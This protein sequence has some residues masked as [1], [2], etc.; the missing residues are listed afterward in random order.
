MISENVFLVD[1]D[2]HNNLASIGARFI[3]FFIDCAIVYTTSAVA[4]S[5]FLQQFVDYS[6]PF[7]IDTILQ[8]L[9]GYL[10]SLLFY[11]LWFVAYFSI[12][13]AVCSQTVGKIILQIKVVDEKN[14]PLTFGSALIRTL[15][16]Y[17]SAIPFFIGFFLS[18]TGTKRQALHDRISGS[19]V[20][21][22]S[23][24]S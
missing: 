22:E 20:I 8:L 11:N 16:Y 6:V 3:A 21:T 10:W 9:E 12:F 23:E 4:S 14:Q 2:S 5:L 15:G 1:H 19:I 13:T 18:L 17:L 7:S 24:T